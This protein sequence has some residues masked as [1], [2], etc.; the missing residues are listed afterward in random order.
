MSTVYVG[1]NKND[2]T[3]AVTDERDCLDCETTTFYSLIMSP[4]V[5]RDYARSLEHMGWAVTFQV[6]E[7]YFETGDSDAE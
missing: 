3:A 1:L 2:H 6:G 5:A 7:E 4:R